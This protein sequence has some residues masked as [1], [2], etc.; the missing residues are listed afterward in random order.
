M[1]AAIPSTAAPQSAD[2]SGANWAS[3]ATFE[4]VL[5]L[6]WLP[7]S[8][9]ARML[10]PEL[11]LAGPGGT[12]RHPALLLFGRYTRGGPLWAGLP[13]PL[14][15]SYQE[16][17]VVLPWLE[18]AG[19]PEPVSQPVLGY[20]DHSIPAWF[21]NEHYGIP[22]QLGPCEWDGTTFVSAGVGAIAAATGPVCHGEILE[23]RSLTQLTE[24]ITAPWMGRTRRGGLAR[25][26]HAWDFSEAQVQAAR[27]VAKAAPE[28]GLPSTWTA[29][30]DA[31]FLLRDVRWRISY[32]QG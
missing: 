12:T 23:S 5:A 22:K 32:P 28:T 17:L 7:A 15:F 30:P 2:A 24:M 29:E 1:T 9:A 14:G 8:L 11:R 10:A 31:S 3:Q 20:A 13:V 16:L 19:I 27:V 25:C 26:D 4:G 18:A 6:H 21:G